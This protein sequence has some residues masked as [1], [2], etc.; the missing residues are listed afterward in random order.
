MEFTDALGLYICSALRCQSV[1]VIAH[2]YQELRI[3]SHSTI[4][5]RRASKDALKGLCRAIR[6]V[7]EATEQRQSRKMYKYVGSAS[8][9]RLQGREEN[10]YNEKRGGFF[11]FLG[12]YDGGGGWRWFLVQGVWWGD[13]GNYKI[14]SKLFSMCVLWVRVLDSPGICPLWFTEPGVGL[15]LG[16]G[17]THL[18]GGTVFLWTVTLHRN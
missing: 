3:A 6:D 10:V 5:S 15:Q 12:Q 9:R 18:K 17:N 4:P 13:T 7:Q 8:K 11:L 16:L 1:W 14:N 2:S